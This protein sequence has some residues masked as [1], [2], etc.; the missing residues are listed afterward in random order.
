MRRFGKLAGSYFR[1]GDT[2]L[3]AL[4]LAASVFGLVLI[5]S[6]TRSYETGRYMLV[7]CLALGVGVVFFVFFSLDFFC[8]NFCHDF[9]IIIRDDF[10]Y[11]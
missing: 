9:Q 8:I 6:A 1:M 2:L 11:A 5:Y 3:L 4:C 10:F 7:Q